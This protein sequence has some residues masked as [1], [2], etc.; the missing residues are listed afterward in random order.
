M[1]NF[2][3]KIIIIVII[4]I[5]LFLFNELFF[6]RV[7]S[8]NIKFNELT[9]YEN[10]SDILTF[11]NIIISSIISYSIYRLSKKI[12]EQ[13]NIE[14]NR[15]RYES[16][17][18]VYDYLNEIILYI[19]KQVFKEK[20]D[21]HKLVYNESFMKEVYNLNNDL[22]DENDISYI[23]F[24]NYNLKNF[25]NEKKQIH[26]DE[27]SIKWV[28]K[29][30]FDL[31]IKINNVDDMNELTDNDILLNV[32]LLHIMSKL[33][34]E[35]NYSYIKKIKYNEIELNVSFKKN[36]INVSK[37]YENQKSISNGRGNIEIYE[38][39]FYKLNN[40]ITF[41]NGGLIYS[42]NVDKY[43]MNGKGTY[44]YHKSNDN[45]VFI[46]SYDLV[47]DNAK[48]IKKLLEKNKIDTK[49]NAKADATFKEGI[50]HSG[51]IS[52]ECEENE[53]IIF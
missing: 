50:M 26:N 49:I 53:P 37:K 15:R 21:Y 6:N 8:S 43:K 48:K 9:H 1:K 46:N 27:L 41:K 29:S 35:L 18:I 19:K 16:I 20:E 40:D 2:G 12:D 17:C 45:D 51:N 3:R 39:I 38:P 7:I 11:I 30:V 32:Q 47:D 42:G 36:K 23:R 25:L 22:L 5:T 44:Y 52:F 34:K 13:A 10:R 4:F 24:L 14:K 28:Y 33:R 31:N